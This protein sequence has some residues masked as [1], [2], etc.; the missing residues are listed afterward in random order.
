M[1]RALAV[2]CLAVVVAGACGGDDDDADSLSADHRPE[3][4]TSTTATPGTTSGAPGAAAGRRRPD[5]DRGD[6]G[7]HADGARG[8][9]G[10]RHALRR[11]AR[12]AACVPLS[13]RHAAASPI[14][15][16]SDD[17]VDRRPSRACST[18][19]SRPTARRST[20]ATAS[21]PDG[22]TRVASYPVSGDAVDTGRPA[23]AAGRR[24]AVPATTTAA[25][26]RSVP[27]ATCTWRWAT[28]AAA[29]T[30]RATGRT[31][32]PCWARSCAST[33]RRRRRRRTASRADNPFADGAAARPRCGST[34][35]ATR[36]A[37]PSTPRPATCG[38][39]TSAR[40]RSRRSTCCPRP[41][42]AARGANLGWNEMEGAHPYEGG[43][44]PDGGVL[45]VFEYDHEDGG[46]S[47]TGGVVYRGT[48]IPGAR[49]RLPV[50]RLLRRAPAGDPGRGR[51]DGRRDH[52]STPR[53]RTWSRSAPTARGEVYVLSLDGAIYRLDPA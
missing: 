35:C 34:G 33:R 38:W 4:D 46:C 24:A 25:T 18:S 53:A 8:A 40:T 42:G 1:R 3:H 17:V 2:V 50:H 41:T 5:A 44:N 14:L 28:A 15:D 16:I 22:D 7:R 47:V 21:A 48:A 20:S 29:A 43:S 30:P 39:P 23:R 27:T 52:A 51:P 10:H 36:G 6:R 45:P 11:R 49:G 37:S 9:G 26:S 13:R 32:R 31:R 12:R 19:S